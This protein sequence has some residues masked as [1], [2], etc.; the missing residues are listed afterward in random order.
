MF[1]Y[2]RLYNR[3][4]VHFYFDPQD[5]AHYEAPDYGGRKL[6]V[7]ALN[8]DSTFEPLLRNYIDVTKLLITVAAASIA[9]G[10]TNS[11]IIAAK[12]VLAFSLLYGVAFVALL[13]FY[14]DDYTQNVG[15]YTPFRYSMIE[16]LGFSTLACFIGG[17]FVWAF[18]LA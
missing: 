14:Y 7:A 2:F 18:N 16:S 6:P 13:Q 8:G 3:K 1:A 4:S 12:I 9:F 10:T 5:F 11:K 17:Y 15:S